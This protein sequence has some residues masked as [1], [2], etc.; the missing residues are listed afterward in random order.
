E[1]VVEGT[2]EGT[3]EGIPEGVVEGTPEGTSEG[4]PEGIEEGEGEIIGRHSADQNNDKRISF[5]ELLRVIQLFNSWGYHCQSGTED[6]FAPGAGGDTSCT[7]HTSDYN[8]PDWKI[9]FTELLRLIQIFNTGGYH[10]CPGESEDNFCP[11]L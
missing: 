10:Y 9:G 7:P 3:P 4:T 11:G 5:T 2:P 8:P 1:G 6:G